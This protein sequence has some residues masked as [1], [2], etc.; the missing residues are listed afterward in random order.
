M[1]EN[2][3]NYGKIIAITVAVISAASA[4]A[5]VIYRLCRSFFTFCD[6]YREDEIDDTDFTFDEI[7]EDETDDDLLIVDE[8]EA[9]EDATQEA[10]EEAPA[11]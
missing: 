10:A 4:I 2:K 9:E 8:E 6:S 5:Y 7:D 1:E 3:T 11:Q